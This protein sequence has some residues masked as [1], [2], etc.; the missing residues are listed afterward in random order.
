MRNFGT[1]VAIASLA[2]GIQVPADAQ[3]P[4]FDTK[5]F[6]ICKGEIEGACDKHDHWVNCDQS[7]TPVIQQ[8]CT[9]NMPDGAKR[10]REYTAENIST[11]SG[12]KCGY[13]HTRAQCAAE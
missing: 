4:K 8:R 2:F 12:N 5:S 13:T 9:V 10:V 1:I 7:E 6:V 11:R 3:V